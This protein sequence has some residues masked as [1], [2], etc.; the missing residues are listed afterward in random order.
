MFDLFL[1]KNPWLV[2]ASSFASDLQKEIEKRVPEASVDLSKIFDLT[3]EGS[4]LNINNFYKEIAKTG[5]KIG[6]SFRLS[7]DE[8]KKHIQF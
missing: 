2:L 5:K 6:P 3:G 1:V 4:P 8:A 7:E